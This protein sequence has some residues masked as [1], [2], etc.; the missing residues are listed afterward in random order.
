MD[1]KHVKSTK[2]SKIIKD[3]KGREIEYQ[4][5]IIEEEVGEGEV[6]AV[7]ESVVE[8]IETTTTTRDSHGNIVD[9]HT[10]VEMHTVDDG[11]AVQAEKEAY[12]LLLSDI[13]HHITLLERGV[14]SS[15]S[16]YSARVLRSLAT[17]RKNLTGK[18]LRGIITSYFPG[19]D[20]E[21]TYLLSC[22]ETSAMDVDAS[23]RKRTERA[24]VLPEAEMYISLLV[25]V[26]L[27]DH[28]E[29]D[30]AARLSS[31]LVHKIST[32]N[33]RSLDHIA[34]KIYF[35]YA[36]AHELLGQFA[37][38]RSTLLLAQRTTAL[39]HDHESQAVLINLILRF[40]FHFHMYDQADKIISKTT[41]PASASNNQLARY[42]YYLG[43]IKAMQLEYTAAYTHLQQASRK[44]PQTAAAAGFLQTI[45]KFMV[46]VQLLIGE[47]P[48]RSLFRQPMLK[49]ALKPYLSIT[50]AV[51]VGDLNMFQETLATCASQFQKD[52]TYT[53]I[54]RLRHNVIKTGIR[55]VNL[56]YSRI[57]LR[58]ICIK[59]SLDSEQDAEYIVAKAIRDGVIDAHIDHA[60]GW[61][62]SLDQADIY[63]TR[64]PEKAFYQRTEFCLA[65]HD[66]AVRAMRYPEKGGAGAHNK[67][68]E[69]LME[70]ER[71]WANDIEGGGGGGGEDDDDDMGFD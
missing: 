5:E 63:K 10:D 20:P 14:A 15:E 58:D 44:A 54:N 60:N 18:R 27:L 2:S 9:Q 67:E 35:Y 31:T 61:L 45:T 39:H 12:T 17:T 41:F 62:Y 37:E 22:I 34:A 8:I 30:K 23:E 38:I 26:Y 25:L 13:K 48:D 49:N 56:S 69:G 19:G 42:M 59:L 21:A 65:L 68:V 29:H 40:Y 43:R 51:R 11:E 4:E 16:R 24:G 70:R 53:L 1:K 52:E 66:E 7:E 32:L 57:S 71:E 36:R 33:R 28:K 55:M 64:E 47:I 3:D 50:Q 6:Y 46:I